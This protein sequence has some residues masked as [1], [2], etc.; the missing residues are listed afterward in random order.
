MDKGTWKQWTVEEKL[1]IL[2]YCDEHSIVKPAQK[3]NVSRFVIYK[4][5]TDLKKVELLL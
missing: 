2:N 3:F 4:W 5:K 1:K